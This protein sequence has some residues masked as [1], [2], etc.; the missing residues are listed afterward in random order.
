MDIL[1]LGKMNQMAKNTNQA[2]ELMA[3]HV[4]E[5]QSEIAEFQATNETNIDSAVSTGLSEIQTLIDTG[6]SSEPHSNTKP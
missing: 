6:V 1:T 2:L 3:N 5:T 4:Y